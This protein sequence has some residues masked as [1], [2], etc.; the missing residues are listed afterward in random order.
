[1]LFS[2]ASD[3]DSLTF[4]LIHTHLP[5]PVN[6]SRAIGNTTLWFAGWQRWHVPAADAPLSSEPHV[7]A[8]GNGM[9]G[10]AGSGEC[11]FSV[12]FVLLKTVCSRASVFHGAMTHDSLVTAWLN[13]NRRS[14]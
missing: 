4:A 9:T 6:H 8:D 2:T 1:M 12:R 14:H 7:S 13:F 11:K 10:E 3:T 5:L